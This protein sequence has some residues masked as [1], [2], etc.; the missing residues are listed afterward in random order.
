[1]ILT[2]DNLNTT[3]P[4]VYKDNK[5]KSDH[6]KQFMIKVK[7]K[8]KIKHLSLN[9]KGFGTQICSV[10]WSQIHQADIYLLDLLRQ[11]LLK[12]ETSVIIDTPVYLTHTSLSN[13]FSTIGRA[14][15]RF[16]LLQFSDTVSLSLLSDPSL[17]L[18][19]LS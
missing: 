14:P 3:T 5:T 17:D 10:S 2:L 4:C 12:C 9:H 15:Y 16:V 18:S 13:D 19:D 7:D 1:M 6:V 8:F 11:G